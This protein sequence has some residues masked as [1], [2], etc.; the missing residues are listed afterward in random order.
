MDEIKRI[1]IDT[2][3]ILLVTTVLVSM[4][5]MLF[6]FLAF[7]SDV[8]HWRKKD[9]DSDM[10]GVSLRT[11]VVNCVT[12]LVILLY[13]QDNNQDTSWMILFVSLVKRNF[14]DLNDR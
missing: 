8:S 11:I 9:K 3:P 10:V 13:L 2:N 6:E 12:Q 7:S 5:H 14:S 4:L 1:L